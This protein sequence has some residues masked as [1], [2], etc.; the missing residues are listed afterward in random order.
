HRAHRRNAG[1]ERARPAAAGRGHGAGRRG[2]A[3]ARPRHVPHP[4]LRAAHGS[5]ADRPR[6]PRRHAGAGLPAL[7]PEASAG[8]ARRARAR[9]PLL[10]RERVLDGAGA[11][12]RVGRG[13]ARALL[14]H[15]RAD[16]VAG[17]RGRPRRGARRTGDRARAVLRRARPRP[18]GAVDGARAG[19]AGSGRAGARAR[20]DPG[21]GGAAR[22]RRLARAQ[23]VA[24]QRGQRRARPLLALGGWAQ[25]LPRP[26]RP[27]LPLGGRARVRRRRARAPA[28][29]VRAD[30]PQLQLVP[31]HRAAVLGGRLRLLGAR[32][33]RG[34][35]ARALR[36]PRQRGGLDE[37]G[38]EGGGRELQPVPRARRAARRR[39]GRARAR[40][41]IAGSRRDRPGDDGGGG[42]RAAR[43]RAPAG[44]AGGRARRARGG[45]GAHGR[46]GPGA[47]GVLPRRATIG[48]E[49]LLGRRRGIRAAGSLPQVLSSLGLVDQHAHGI[50]REPPATLDAFRGL[51]S[52]SGQPEQW[53]H[54]AT[55]ATYR[56]AIRELASFLGC[57]PT[58]SAVYERRL[59]T[60][61]D[62]YAS[63]LLRATGTEWLLLDDG[64]PAPD[65]GEGWQ[66]MGE[67]AGCASAPVLRIERVAEEALAAGERRLDELLERVRD[68]V[69]RARAGGW[70]ALKTIAAYRSGLDV[71]P[72]DDAA[73][74]EALAR[75]GRRLEAK[76]L[77]DAVLHAA[78]EANERAGPLPVQVHCGFGDEDLLLP[79]ARPGLLGSLLERYRAT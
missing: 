66:R 41:R 67:L 52:E 39:A 49:R 56:R 23:A 9:A 45:P 15:H 78:L 2:A 25:P 29:P 50:L 79:A 4:A 74:A 72:P 58:E 43:D 60:P 70:A 55:S 30:R 14:P 77:V 71:G 42:A 12:R 21:R 24:G 48:V 27:R 18:A 38:A 69:T 31:P 51:F 8:E 22:A 59:A 17:L 46:A 34:A 68:A 57:E 62:E 26:G 64:F 37:R 36:L 1:D 54:V 76:P 40:P 33:P 3:R 75:G 7:V 32:Q 20:D 44:D 11:E 47:R 35:A 53:P 16:R 6:R 5:A 63:S 65:E 19:A 61:A 10:V 28:G 13:G 73:A